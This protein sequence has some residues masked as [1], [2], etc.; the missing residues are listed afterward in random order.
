MNISKNENCKK[1]KKKWK[2]KK[3]KIA[4]KNCG[5]FKKK[6]KLQK[7]CVKWKLEKMK[8]AFVLTNE[9]WKKK[10]KLQKKWKLKK[11]WAKK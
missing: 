9:N 5:K 6:W 11:F 2:L 8:I 3:M 10:W 7:N 1:V 4:K